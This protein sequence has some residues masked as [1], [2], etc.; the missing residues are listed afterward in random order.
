MPSPI[1]EFFEVIAEEL[2]SDPA[3]VITSADLQVN[4]DQAPL[5]EALKTETR[6]ATNEQA[7][8]VAVTLLDTHFKGK[9]S[10]LPFQ[11]DSKTG[12]FEALDLPYLKFIKEMSNIRSIGKRSREFEL[13]VWDKLGSRV[14]GSLHRVGHPRE[15]KGRQ[16]EFNAYLRTLGFMGKVLLGQEKDGGLDILWLLPIGTKPH[17]PIVSVQCK[18]GVFDMD[19]G[20]KSV[21]AGSRSLAMHGGLQ[22]TVHVPCVLFND[23]LYPEVVTAKPMNFVP[24]GLTD[25]SPM[26]KLFFAEAI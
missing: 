1:F 4:Q 21:G 6:T 11:Y 15:R 13:G 2:S 10:K 19:A 25:L 23:Y 5:F 18:N 7:I 14:T 17:Q 9:G 8:R 20:D 16:S 24:L 26:V 12:L 22:A 3:R